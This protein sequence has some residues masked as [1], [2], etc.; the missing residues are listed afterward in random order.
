MKKVLI[1][2]LSLLLLFN[3]CACSSTSTPKGTAESFM[4]ALKNGDTKT[5]QKIYL[6]DSDEARMLANYANNIINSKAFKEISS[7]LDDD[8]FGFE[9]KVKEIEQDGDEAIAY[10][11]ITC[12]DWET[13]MTDISV[14]LLPNMLGLLLNGAS[15]KKIKNEVQKFI[16]EERK[17]VPDKEYDIGIRLIKKDKEWKID[18]RGLMDQLYDDYD[19]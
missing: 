7:Y 8:F 6:G 9:Y 14:E 12:E 2:L 3:L 16:K 17:N 11:R 15:E 19:Y 4:K 1:A 18:G 5:I 13:I 10:V